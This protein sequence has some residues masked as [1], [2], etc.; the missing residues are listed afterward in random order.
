M[1]TETI[2]V[3]FKCKF[4][5]ERVGN[6]NTWD[7]RPYFFPQHSMPSV[8][9]LPVV[10]RLLPNLFW[11]SLKPP[12]RIPWRRVCELSVLLPTSLYTLQALRWTGVFTNHFLMGN[13]H[14]KRETTLFLQLT[15]LH[16]KMK[17]CPEQNDMDWNC[18]Y[19]THS[20]T[21]TEII[22]S[23]NP[24]LKKPVYSLSSRSVINQDLGKN[25]KFFQEPHPIIQSVYSKL[26]MRV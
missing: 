19:R 2:I 24:H 10:S 9:C 14:T 17:L 18:L 13:K 26:A 25:W 23:S 4:Q 12:K 20:I 1:K 3:T 16:Y 7:S 11:L 6:T 22:E 21:S 15:G 8:Y 5:R